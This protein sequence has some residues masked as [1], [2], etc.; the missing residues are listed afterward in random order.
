MKIILKINTVFLKLCIALLFI[1]LVI[2]C[3]ENKSSENLQ[4]LKQDTGVTLDKDVFKEW[5]NWVNKKDSVAFYPAG[6]IIVYYANMCNTS[7]VSDNN[8]MDASPLPDELIIP[9]G[10][11]Q[12][13]G[14]TFELQKEG[15]YRFM[16][17]G[18]EQQQRIVYKKDLYSLLS[19]ISWIVSHGNS[20]HIYSLETRTELA[21]T[22]KLFMNCG[23]ISAWAKSLL[24]GQSIRS[25]IVY[26]TTLNNRNKFDNGHV[27]IEVY[28]EYL[29]RWVVFDL[30]MN[31]YFTID[32]KPISFIE[33]AYA[34]NSRLPYKIIP[35]SRDI[36]L[37]VSNF[38]NKK[39]TDYAFVMERLL[40][41]VRKWYRRV[42]QVPFIDNTF[43]DKDNRTII[44]ELYP[45]RNYMDAAEFKRTFYGETTTSE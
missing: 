41:L 27:L 20:D 3:E 43:F 19:A 14:E 7:L 40:P 24:D 45:S 42:L 31:C 38:K 11:Y 25:R 29:R 35:I 6:D 4:Y 39:G 12:F 33:F 22:R 15:L 34:V 28:H 36:L 26:S 13:R 8:K 18:K 1:S 5:G 32:Q 2:G 16:E 23:G 37:D 30:D 21:K 9:S 17:V 44:K 10:V